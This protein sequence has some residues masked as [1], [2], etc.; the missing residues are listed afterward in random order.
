[1]EHISTAAQH[2]KDN[3]KNKLPGKTTSVF[4]NKAPDGLEIKFHELLTTEAIDFL[5]DLVSHFDDQVNDLYSQRLQRKSELNKKPKIPRFKKLNVQ[6][7]WK[8]AP[9]SK[10][11]KIKKNKIL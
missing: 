10:Y 6:E 4:I 9:V 5:V 7:D 3:I 2:L 8:V 1:M 11:L